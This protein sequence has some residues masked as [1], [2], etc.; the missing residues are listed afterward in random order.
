MTFGEALKALNIEDFGERIFNSN[1][2]GE[3]FH[4]VQYSH[5]VEILEKMGQLDEFRGWFLRL[6]EMAESEWDR[7]ESIFQ[8]V[9]EFFADSMKGVS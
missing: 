9:L 7:P 5:L 1:S 6:V 8:H 3:L 2:H 4:L